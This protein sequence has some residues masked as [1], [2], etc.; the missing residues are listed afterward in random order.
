MVVHL[1]TTIAS[2]YGPTELVTHDAA[3]LLDVPVP[4]GNGES[5]PVAIHS[6]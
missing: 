6:S 1:V 4:N 2:G 3:P 5:V